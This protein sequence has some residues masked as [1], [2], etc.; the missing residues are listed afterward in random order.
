MHL[1]LSYLQSD[2]RYYFTWIIIVTFSICVHEW[3]HAAMALR[4]GDD[5]AA[6]A[7]HLSL[8]PLVQMGPTSL[9]YLAIIGIA[10]GMVPVDVSQLRKRGQEALVAFAGPL[11]NFVLMMIFSLLFMVVS[12]L[13]PMEENSFVP[14]LYEA[15]R[16]NA[17]LFLLNMLPIPIL[18][19][20][21][22]LSH[23][24]PRMKMLP[25]ET[26]MSIATMC[27]LAIFITPLGNLLWQGGEAFSRWSMKGWLLLLRVFGL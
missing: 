26:A 5:T 14:I 21:T 13:I 27:I 15:S 23:F 1:F 10:W 8:N 6:R 7:G 20:W 25:R 17:V 18:D 2:P 19:G 3:A 16:A 22:V 9:F 24:I 4:C 11:A 12:A